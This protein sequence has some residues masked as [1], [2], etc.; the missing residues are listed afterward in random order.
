MLA[1]DAADKLGW[2]KPIALHTPLIPGLKGGSRMNPEGV[3]ELQK[4]EVEVCKLDD[5]KPGI[6]EQ[7]SV[8]IEMKMSK[9]DPT[10]SI[11]IHDT[12][13]DVRKKIKKAYCPPEKEKENE[14]PMLMMARYIIFPRFGRIDIKRPEKYG[15]D[16][17]Y[18]SYEELT[19]AYFG[20]KL[21][22]VDLKTGIADS[23][24]ALLAPV[25][26][27]FAAHPENYER[28]KEIF[29]SVKKLR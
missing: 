12:P 15:G 4:K 11:N 22:P 21:S 6:E 8:M 24:N 1:R 23:I 26:E 13:D 5:K 3:K 28:M 10:S 19:D 7:A 29:A 14:N 9:S 27:Y 2:K 18:S 25:A 20:G 16:V 17:S